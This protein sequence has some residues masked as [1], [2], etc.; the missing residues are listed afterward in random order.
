ME[1]ATSSPDEDPDDQVVQAI[2]EAL[3]RRLAMPRRDGAPADGLGDVLGD[4]GPHRDHG[5]VA[6][7]GLVSEVGH[8]HL[9]PFCVT[10][11]ADSG[12]CSA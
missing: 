10:T 12:G 8:V 1:W 2:R 6:E 5:H 4:D 7:R 11:L 3:D 9:C